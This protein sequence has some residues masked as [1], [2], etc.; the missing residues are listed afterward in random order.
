MIPL[1]SPT[2]PSSHEPV[3][4]HGNYNVGFASRQKFVKDC[5][6]KNL[7]LQLNR[8]GFFESLT[9][10]IHP[11]GK[12]SIEREFEKDDVMFRTADLDGNNPARYI[13]AKLVLWVPRVTFSSVSVKPRHYTTTKV[14]LLK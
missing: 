1:V 13:V 8:N 14:E 4:K 10:Q 6:I 2:S 9:D 3:T 11:A 12:V 7:I 5:E